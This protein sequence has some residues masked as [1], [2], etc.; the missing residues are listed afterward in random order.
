MHRRLRDFFFGL[1]YPR[2]HFIVEMGAA[3]QLPLRD[4]P[5]LLASVAPPPKFSE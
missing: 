5:L 4:Y 2:F 1:R 3:L